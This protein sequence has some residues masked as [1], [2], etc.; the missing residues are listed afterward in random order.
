MSKDRLLENENRRQIVAIINARQGITFTDLMEE[1]G[2]RNGATAYHTYTLERRRYIKSVKDGKYRRFYPRGA[3]VTGL[4]SLEESITEVIKSN[5]SI[6]QREIADFIGSTPQTVNY[7]IK[8]LI[9]R[10][11]VHLIKEGK[12]TKC[13]LTNLYNTQYN[14]AEA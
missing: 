8:K 1:T 2:L 14:R 9:E 12:C 10:G 13:D 3:R 6:S 5:P 11:L 7:N 4:S